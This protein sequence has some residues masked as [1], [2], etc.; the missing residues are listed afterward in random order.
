MFNNVDIGC[1]I[2]YKVNGNVY[3]VQFFIILVYV[4]GDDIRFKIKVVNF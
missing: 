3:V 1:I 2:Q 4:V